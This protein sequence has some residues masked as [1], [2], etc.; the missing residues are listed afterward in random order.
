MTK[1]LEAIVSGRVQMVMFRDFVQRKAS[2][3]RLTGEVRNLKD[4]TVR[5]LAEGEHTSLER[6]HKH[7]HRGPLLAQV[8]NVSV[9]WTEAKNDFFS[10]KIAY[11]D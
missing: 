7:L 11:G 6:L 2:A 1:R 5:V 9:I 4:G 3:L 10:F 8:E